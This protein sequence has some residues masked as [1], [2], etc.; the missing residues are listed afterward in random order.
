[1]R[2]E[3]GKKYTLN[4]NAS[5]KSYSAVTQLPPVDRRI[6]SLWWKPAPANADTSLV[7]VFSRVTDPPG[8]GNFIRYFTSVN[9]SSFLPG[10]NSVFDDQIIDGTTYDIQVF[11]GVNRNVP[12]NNETFGYFRRG[13]KV[14]VKLSNIDKA[15][16]DFW[17]TW[18]Q[19]QANIGNPF[20]VPIRVLG[21]ISNGAVGY[22]GGYGSQVMEITIPK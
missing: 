11:R 14:Q 9:D 17:R 3:F 10:I 13:E 16:F 22:F 20:G 12:I 1:M 19:N 6:D 5:G 4:I 7:V 2:G 18:E 8:F 15:T 21:N